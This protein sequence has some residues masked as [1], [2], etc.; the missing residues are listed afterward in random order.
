MRHWSQG[1]QRKRRRGESWRWRVEGWRLADFHAV[2]SISLRGYATD[3][4]M[5][6]AVV[7]EWWP[8]SM[9]SRRTYMREGWRMQRQGVPLEELT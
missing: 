9:P 8:E 2:D 6:V 5:R 7:R 4:E 1:P 3:D